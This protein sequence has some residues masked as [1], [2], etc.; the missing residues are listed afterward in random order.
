[1]TDADLRFDVINALAQTPDIRALPAYLEGMGGKNV[2]QREDCANAVSALK[3]EALPAIE[4]RLAKKPPLSADV[5]VQLQK[6]YANDPAAAKSRLFSIE[7]N[8][9]ALENTLPRSRS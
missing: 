9:L 1:M 8:T 3:K 4:A 7:V 5:I 2:D 6:V